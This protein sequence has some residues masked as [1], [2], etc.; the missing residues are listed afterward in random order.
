MSIVGVPSKYGK[1]EPSMSIVGVTL[2]QEVR[3]DPD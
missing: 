3:Y 1:V 2:L